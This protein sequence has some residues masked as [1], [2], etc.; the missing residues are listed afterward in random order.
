MADPLLPSVRLLAPDI[1]EVRGE[2]V[3]LDARVA[4][5]FGTET[6]RVN[7]AVARNPEKF[8]PTHAFQ[9]SPAEHDA[10]RSQ[11]ATSNAG[12]GGP[13]Y[14]PHV[15]TIKGV[16][17]LATVLNTDEALRAT[18]LIIDTF[19]LVY[20]QVADGR[21]RIA[22]P[23]PSQYRSS[24]E[25][26][27]AIQKF[28]GRLVDALT[29]LLDS[30]VDVQSKRTVREVAQHLGSE[31][32]QHMQE[33]LRTRGMQ[34]AKLE[35]DTGLL[36]AQA[37]QVL[38]ATRKTHAEADTIGIQNLERR[39]DVVKKLIDMSRDLEPAEFVQLLDTFEGKADPELIGSPGDTKRIGGK[40][41]A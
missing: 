33:R 5:S 30:V 8:S 39:I 6:K 20:A 12:R 36:L 10:L 9:L 25:S 31:A 29:A 24:P 16:A 4:Q 19:L 11:A 27:R 34:N 40:A 41:P 38:A 2:R 1:F 35:A 18:D 15:F 22:I 13:R 32:L 26:R 3:M 17:R 28:R 14:P 23:Q 7:E 21:A 37:E